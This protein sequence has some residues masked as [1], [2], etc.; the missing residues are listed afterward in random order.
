MARPVR[1]KRIPKYTTPRSRPDARLANHS[2][3][4]SGLGQGAFGDVGTA[5]C[6]TKESS[7][8]S[9]GRMSIPSGAKPLESQ[10]G[11]IP[12]RDA[13]TTRSRLSPTPAGHYERGTLLSCPAT[14]EC[15]PSPTREKRALQSAASTDSGAHRSRNWSRS[16]N[17]DSRSASVSWSQSHHS[18]SSMRAA[19]SELNRRRMGSAGT[20][21]TTV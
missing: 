14:Q 11:T 17:A 15:A 2:R 1:C 8:F 20:P 5:C 3:D 4:P 6:P 18:V 9:A 16:R 12:A 13:G 7:R 19:T 21:A 10:S